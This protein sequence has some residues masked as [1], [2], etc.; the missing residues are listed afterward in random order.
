[1]NLEAKLEA[2]LF[3]S[4]KPL[5]VKQL[6]E[7]AEVEANAVV[8]GLRLLAERLQA[9]DSGIMVSENDNKYQLATVPAAADFVSKLVKSELSGEL[10]RPSLETLTI[11]AYRGPISK[12]DLDRIRGVNCA[13]ILRNLLLRGLIE[14]KNGTNEGGIFYSVSFEFLRFLGVSSV[15]DLPEY[16]RLSQEASIEAA[17]RGEETLPLE[18]AV[19]AANV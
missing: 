16:E 19:D 8:E 11:I 15:K 1:M 13:M 7:L 9:T 12:P 18:D 10:T 5:S 2:L 6:A 17:V 14:A 4:P 3:V